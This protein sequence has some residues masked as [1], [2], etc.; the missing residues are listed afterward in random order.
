ML[1]IRTPVLMTTLAL[2]SSSVAVA[3]Q[4][5]HRH[6]GRGMMG[7]GAGMMT[8][9]DRFR[10]ANVLLQKESLSL[11]RTQ[12][13]K[14]TDLENGAAKTREA[15]LAGHEQNRGQLMGALAAP[16]PDPMAVRGYFDAAHAS[17][18]AA[19]WADI[20][21]ALKAMQILTDEQRHMVKP[22][23]EPGS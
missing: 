12:I 10:P 15:A 4:Q 17:M 5:Q 3:Q 18:G 2:L 1:N 13:E 8:H 11:S 21:A 9:I 14:L 20:D 19:H 22:G 7:Q 23:A 16:A 6:Q